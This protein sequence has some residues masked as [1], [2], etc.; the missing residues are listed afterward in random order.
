MYT[1]PLEKLWWMATMK[2]IAKWDWEIPLALL[3][4]EFTAKILKPKIQRFDF[5]VKS[6]WKFYGKTKQ[7]V[8]PHILGVTGAPLERVQWVPIWI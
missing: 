1:D 6:K 7:R 5:H 8:Y 4:V 2:D 3:D